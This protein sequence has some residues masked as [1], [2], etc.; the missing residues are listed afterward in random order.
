[1][2]ALDIIGVT[3]HADNLRA[4]ILDPMIKDIRNSCGPGSPRD[5]T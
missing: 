5:L 2:N 4:G 1:M 3:Q